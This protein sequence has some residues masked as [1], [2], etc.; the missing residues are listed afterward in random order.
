MFCRYPQSP[1]NRTDYQ[2]VVHLE[3]ELDTDDQQTDSEYKWRELDIT[4]EQ[5]YKVSQVWGH[6]TMSQFL[7]GWWIW[8]TDG[9]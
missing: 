2:T 7:L 8:M 5:I 3:T 6:L 4:M 1:D 9:G